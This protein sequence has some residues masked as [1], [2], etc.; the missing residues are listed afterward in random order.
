MKRIHPSID[1]VEKLYGEQ[2]PKAA[3]DYRFTCHGIHIRCAEGVLLYHSM[4]GEL[5]LLSEDE[6]EN[7]ERDAALRENLIRRWFLVPED[8]DEKKHVDQVLTVLRLM[9]KKKQNIRNFTVLPT[10]DCD[11]RCYYCF[12]LGRPR[13]S[14]DER[15]ARDVADYIARVSGGDEISIKWFGGEPLYNAAAIDVI[16]QE[17]KRKGLRYR[18]TMTT[19]GYLFDEALVR[20]AKED[21][22]LERVQITLDGTEAVYNR[23][24]AYIYREGNPFRRVM[25]NIGLLLDAEL[26]VSVR[27]NMGQRNADD[28]ERLVQTLAERFSD[29]AGFFVYAERLADINQDGRVIQGENAANKIREL[30]KKIRALGLNHSVLQDTFRLNGCMADSDSSLTILPDGRLGKCEAESDDK[31]VGSIYAETLDQ[32]MIAAW[33]ERMSCQLCES[34]VLYPQCRHPKLCRL[35]NTECTEYIQQNLRRRLE[36]MIL[37]TYEEARVEHEAD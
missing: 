19:N 32:S 35:A 29:K 1:T 28:L 21:W 15:T 25:R 23:V 16:T 26:K 31:L 8:H 24:K 14:M 2:M 17:L 12:E 36:D 33:K 4:T 13:R 10:T 5:I 18:S 3:A 27:L 7:R 20:K 34:C 30:N 37:D 9:Q 11:A 22:K 6:W